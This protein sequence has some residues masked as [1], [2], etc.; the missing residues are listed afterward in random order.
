M[1]ELKKKIQN[2]K[3]DCVGRSLAMQ[4]MHVIFELMI[5]KYTFKAKDNHSN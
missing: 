2:D 1:M 3:E 4:T 5:N